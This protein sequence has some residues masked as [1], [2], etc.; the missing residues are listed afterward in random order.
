MAAETKGLL[1]GELEIEDIANIIKHKF[2]CDLE[3]KQNSTFYYFNDIGKRVYDKSGYIIFNINNEKFMAHY[4]FTSNQ[5]ENYN[6]LNID[7]SKE[8]TQILFDYREKTPKIMK[9]IVEETGGYIV[10]NTDENDKF[11][12]VTKNK[13]FDIPDVLHLSLKDI[14]DRF[15]NYVI[16]DD[17]RL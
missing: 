7:L 9:L 11:K 6:N 2:N 12:I 1:E 16:I 15:G 8:Y 4:Y 17:Y 13:S 10:D 14:Y 3:L 5:L